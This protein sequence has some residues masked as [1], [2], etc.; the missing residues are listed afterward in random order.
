M[1]K[2]LPGVSRKDRIPF[3]GRM[4]KIFLKIG[5]QE[6]YTEITSEIGSLVDDLVELSL[7]DTEDNGKCDIST[8]GGG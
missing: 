7:E 1:N 4:I 8:P 2:I 5:F 3:S 6:E